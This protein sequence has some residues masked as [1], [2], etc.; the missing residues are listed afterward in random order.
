[1][2]HHQAAQPDLLPQGLGNEAESEI[3]NK[4]KKN[5]A[6]AWACG[7]ESQ[8]PRADI[9]QAHNHVVRVSQNLAA[10]A[11]QSG[12]FQLGGSSGSGAPGVK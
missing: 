10:K 3:L 2:P 1:M 8:C 6:Q 9:K 11:E 5:K 7:L 4:L 12:C